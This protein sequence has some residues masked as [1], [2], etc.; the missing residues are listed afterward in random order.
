MKDLID[1]LERVS[2]K[3]DCQNGDQLSQGTGTIVSDSDR[4]FVLTAAHVISKDCETANADG[5]ISCRLLINKKDVLL[6]VKNVIYIDSC[7]D[8][9]AAIIEIEKPVTDFD[10]TN[11]VKL[12]N[13]IVDGEKFYMYGFTEKA[14][15]G[16]RFDLSISA[17]DTWHVNNA[18]I[19]SSCIEVKKLLGGNSGAAIFF[20]RYNVMYIVGIAKELLSYDGA[21]SDF[22]MRKSEIYKAH[23][24]SNIFENDVIAL[25]ERWNSLRMEE[26]QNELRKELKEN[27]VAWLDNLERKARV[28]YT[29]DTEREE[30]IKMYIS[31]YCKGNVFVENIIRKS[32][33]LYNKIVEEMTITLNT[34]QYSNSIFV[35][36]VNMAQM[37]LKDLFNEYQNCFS[38]VINETGTENA[39]RLFLGLA[40]YNIASDLLRCNI[41]F[42]LKDDR[43]KN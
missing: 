9:D 28:L 24:S 19:D 1:M 42:V 32:P 34:F 10:Y 15:H 21:Y 16:R 23:L 7:E 25:V 40:K 38:T 35:D 36:N 12:C 31:D 6:T 41:N 13:A 26:Q 18:N 39:R 22:I 2:V 11:K 30:M 14:P 5:E 37:K 17:T 4:Y 27:K 8:V 3:I 33:S 20:Y 43:D 29:N